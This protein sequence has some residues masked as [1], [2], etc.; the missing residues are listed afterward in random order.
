MPAGDTPAGASA[1]AI[2]LGYYDTDAVRTI[3]QNGTT[4]TYTLDTA[5][6][7]AVE[8]TGP[9]G[10]AVA[11][12]VKSHFTDSSDNP[13]WVEKTADGATTTSRY[14]ESL[15]GDLSA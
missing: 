2:T 10:G 11:T 13:S 12:R 7:R 15:G 3:T 1:G 9:A 4:S 5:G 8:E 14:L 6:R